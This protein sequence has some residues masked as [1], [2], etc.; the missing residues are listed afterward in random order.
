[1]SVSVTSSAAPWFTN[2]LAVSD[3]GYGNETMRLSGPTARRR[4]ASAPARVHAYGLSA[5]TSARPAHIA[6]DS[7]WASVEAETLVGA[8]RVLVEREAV[9]GAARC[10]RR[11]RAAARALNAGNVGRP[12]RRCPRHVDARSACACHGTGALGAR[13]QHDAGVAGGDPRRGSV[14]RADRRLAAGRVDPARARGLDVEPA[15][16]RRPAHRGRRTATRRPA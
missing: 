3:F 12:P 8:Q 9:E 7:A 1:M 13:R 16:A 4:A 14:E 6:A 15:A 10:R 11:R 5:A 2:G